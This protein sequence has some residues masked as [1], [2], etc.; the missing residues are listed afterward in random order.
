MSTFLLKVYAADKIFYEGQCEYVSVPTPMGQ[1]GVLKDHRNTICAV[2]PGILTYKIEGEDKKAAVSKG[3][4]K[5]EDNEV[6]VLV[7]TCE[8]P[9]EIDINR[10]MRAEEEARRILK[11]KKSKQEYLMAQANLARAISRLRLKNNYGK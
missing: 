5:I 6:L 3:M 8:K 10:A 1:Y 2:I 9:E 4:I 11:Q 7:N